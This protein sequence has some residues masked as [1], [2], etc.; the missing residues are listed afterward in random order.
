MADVF[1]AGS[2]QPGLRPER[3]APSR[4]WRDCH[5]RPSGDPQ[6]RQG[7][8]PGRRRGP[9][10]ASVAFLGRVGDDG[11]GAPLVEG[12]PIRASIRALCRRFPVRPQARPS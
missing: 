4:A 1:V 9:P 5:G 2:D 7:G 10:R 3:R 12:S 6:R 8:Q 11:F